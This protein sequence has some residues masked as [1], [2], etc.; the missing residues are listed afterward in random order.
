MTVMEFEY[1]I[2][3]SIDFYDFFLCGFSSQN[4]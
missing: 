4:S 2:S 3:F 1:M